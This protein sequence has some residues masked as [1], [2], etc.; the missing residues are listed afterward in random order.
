M[1]SKTFSFDDYDAIGVDLDHTLCKYNLDTTFP[2]SILWG[3][4]IKPSWVGNKDNY[5]STFII[6]EKI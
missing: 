5:G 2:V 3:L 4:L 6:F 1:A